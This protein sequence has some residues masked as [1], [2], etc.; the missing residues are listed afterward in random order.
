MALKTNTLLVV[1]LWLSGLAENSVYSFSSISA[2]ANFFPSPA[3]RHDR[4]RTQEV[5][6]SPRIRSVSEEDVNSISDIWARC[7]TDPDGHELIG[8]P[9]RFNFRRRMDF[10]KTKDGVKKILSSRLK[11]IRVGETIMEEC[12]LHFEEDVLTE[13][14]KLRYLWSNESFLNCM[15]RAAKLSKEPHVWN[16]YNF[17]CAP[18][19][20]EW[21]RHKMFAAED[22]ISGNVLGFCEIAMLHDPLSEEPTARPTLVNLVVNPEFRRLGVASK[23]IQSAQTFVE[24][25]WLSSTLN[26][27]VNSDNQAAVSLYRHLG[28][29]I[30]G[31]ARHPELDVR[32]KYMSLQLQTTCS[33]K[34]LGN[35]HNCIT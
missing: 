5:V 17:A 8:N 29:H 7:I 34:Q 31:E 35:Q 26:L 16:Q 33:R 30:A 32:Q 25:Q 14:Q 12:S 10:L 1:F 24:R 13:S 22:R 23:I 2:G 19:S 28:F 27:F 21:L 18:K 20:S 4:S 9:A 6:I 15:E 11:A 3:E